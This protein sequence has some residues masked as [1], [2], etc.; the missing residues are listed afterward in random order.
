M[1][2]EAE[3]KDRDLNYW[4]D[5]VL[6]EKSSYAYPVVKLAELA[7]EMLDA[8]KFQFDGAHDHRYYVNVNDRIVAILG[9]SEILGEKDEF[10]YSWS[11]GYESLEHKIHGAASLHYSGTYHPKGICE[12]NGG[13]IWCGSV[14]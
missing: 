11:N 1:T 9:G 6:E 3:E 5:R 8:S 4:V 12:G 2:T 7:K 13:C 10:S 14:L